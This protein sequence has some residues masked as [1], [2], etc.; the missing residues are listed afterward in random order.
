M[1]KITKTI[2][3]FLFLFIV[4]SGVKSVS[5]ATRVITSD[6]VLDAD[7][8]EGI[9]IPA[10]ANVTLDLGG[11][12]VSGTSS[13]VIGTTSNQGTIVNEGTL[14]IEGQGEVISTSQYTILNRGGDLTINGGTY[15]GNSGASLI[16]NGWYKP[17]ENTSGE[18]TKLTIND[19]V[20]RG[21]LYNVKNDGY[22]KLVINGGSFEEPDGSDNF[23][24]FTAG[25]STIINDG[26]F[27]QSIVLKLSGSDAVKQFVINKADFTS[28]SA[29]IYFDKTD[30]GA[31]YSG[32]NIY[33]D[34]VIKNVTVSQIRFDNNTGNC[35]DIENFLLE[36]V[37]ATYTGNYS[38]AYNG[39]G[40]VI[41]NNVSAPNGTNK[42][43]I[44][45]SA[46]SVQIIGGEYQT[47]Y[48]GGPKASI[49]AV[50]E[51]VT[52]NKQL[53]VQRPANKVT[54]ESGNYEEVMTYA[55]SN[56]AAL[57]GNVVINGGTINKVNGYCTGKIDI[58]AGIITG[59]VKAD[60]A[61]TINITGGYFGGTLSNKSTKGS[62]GT[63]NITGGMFE[64]SPDE[65]F[66]DS[67][68]VEMET[69]DGV[70]VVVKES[71]IKNEVLSGPMPEEYIDSDEI[72]LISKAI[73]DKYTL[74]EY[75]E[76]LY[77]RVTPNYEIVGLIEE[78]SEDIEVTLGLPDELPELKD[79]Y[80]RKYVIV[81]VHDG[82]A[83]IIEDVTLSEDDNTITF[84]TNKF[85][86]YAVAYVDSQN[87]TES[88]S[89]STSG[90]SDSVANPNTSDN[91]I[92][93]VGIFVLSAALMIVL[94]KQPK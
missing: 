76:V 33:R 17:S 22:G 52:V 39:G 6:T 53:Y 16:D 46:N 80:T 77:A 36:N 32:D 88:G 5:A 9:Y 58:N 14:V 44:A 85:S 23:N 24:I 61:S 74:L 86:T 25:A 28:A 83:D 54:I 89:A 18:Y 94:K 51:G 64:I 35:D 62:N 66:V 91:I 19:G 78:A 2:F 30:D 21:G 45:G 68:Y 70:T 4:V 50:L 37:V 11:H 26:T 3:M 13:Y 60:N 1:N 55:S 34:V 42:A 73:K 15:I 10:G 65:A 41:L 29:M 7:E 81:R 84:K 79:G 92:A 40:E 56:K 93:F 63:I 67:E 71:D 49:D 43:Y 72:T 75:Y 82:D 90:K 87:E 48:F 20:F 47:L 12:T 69:I 27:D 38:I 31:T 59:A 8:T 57:G